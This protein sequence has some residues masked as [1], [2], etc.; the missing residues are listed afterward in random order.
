MQLHY[1]WE[2]LT[3]VSTPIDRPI[4]TDSE[5]LSAYWVRI[6]MIAIGCLGWLVSTARHDVAYAHSRIAQH[7]AAPTTSAL[8]ALK[9]VY[10][11]LKGT[12]H[13][14]IRGLINGSDTDL[15]NPQAAQSPVHP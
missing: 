4:D 3:A 2:D 14:C 10:R 12:S 9:R 11:Y 7:Q 15:M 1:T 8:D 6:F 5:L 13:Y